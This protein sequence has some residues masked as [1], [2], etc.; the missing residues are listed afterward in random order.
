M[1][2]RSD[3]KGSRVAI[4]GDLDA[5]TLS[6]GANTQ[7]LGEIRGRGNVVE[8]ADTLNPQS[9]YVSIFGNG[10]HIQIGRRSL[11]QNMRIDIG[12]KRW[13]CSRSRLTIGESFSIGSSGRFILP[14]SGNVVEIGKDCM[15]SNSIQLRAGEYPHLIF[16]DESGSYLDVSEGIF[17]GDHAW[18]GEGAYITKAVTIGRESIV[19]ARSVVTKRFDEEHVVIAGNPAR[20]VKRGVRWIANE[21]HFAGRDDLEASFQAAEVHRINAEERGL[22]KADQAPV[23][24]PQDRSFGKSD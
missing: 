21:Q 18:I 20:I 9:V 10:N 11:L 22:N 17:I 4:T 23:A 13:P 15:F 24:P 16:D 19:G 5:N 8:I 3:K 2:G 7:L 6:I 1:V 12:S 14:N